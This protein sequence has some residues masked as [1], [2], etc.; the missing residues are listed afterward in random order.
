[1]KFCFERRKMH[2]LIKENNDFK[3]Q[4]LFAYGDTKHMQYCC[5]FSFYKNILK[6]QQS[7][8][9]NIFMVKNEVE[10]EIEKPSEEILC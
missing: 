5:I 2:A 8:Y 3:Y 9:Y 6:N 7:H 1:M 10:S 4:V